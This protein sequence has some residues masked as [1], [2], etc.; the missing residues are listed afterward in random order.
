MR[1]IY[2]YVRAHLIFRGTR[3]PAARVS[4]AIHLDVRWLSS[5][6]SR[7]TPLARL[8]TARVFVVV[9]IA[10]RV[11]T[12]VRPIAKANAFGASA[13][14]GS[15]HTL[16]IDEGT[17]QVSFAP[18][19]ALDGGLSFGH[20]IW[21]G[22]RWH[23]GQQ[24]AKLAASERPGRSRR[25]LACARFQVAARPLMNLGRGRLYA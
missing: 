4:C 18:P 11:S 13:R 23:A 21:L 14:L 24:C 22:A 6:R 2:K 9:F 12:K 5:G 17:Y 25:G 20:I 10:R 19:E 3:R 1:K 15:A 7:E 8:H 16:F